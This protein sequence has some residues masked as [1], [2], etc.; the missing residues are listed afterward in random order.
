MEFTYHVT[1]QDLMEFGQHVF[2]TSSRMRRKRRFWLSFAAGMFVVFAME[3]YWKTRA[4]DW[5]FF[6]IVSQVVCSAVFFPRFYDRVLLKQIYRS[7]IS[8]PALGDTGVIRL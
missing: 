8:R 1:L 4:F 6:A 7:Y 5:L 2:R 3:Y